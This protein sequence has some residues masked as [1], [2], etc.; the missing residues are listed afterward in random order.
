MAG[1]CHVAFTLR[2]KVLTSFADCH[3]LP[4][5]LTSSQWT[6][7]TAMAS[8]Q[9]KECVQLAIAPTTQLIITDHSTLAHKLLG[10]FRLSLLIWYEYVTWYCCTLHNCV[11]CAY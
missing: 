10:F 4:R 6:E 11:Q 8:F 7:G 9:W 1:F 2:S 3:C 5:F